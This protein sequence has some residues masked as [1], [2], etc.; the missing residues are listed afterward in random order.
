MTVVTLLAFLSAACLPPVPTPGRAGQVKRVLI[1]GDSVTFGL[2]GTS[3]QVQTPLRVMLADRGVDL[4]VQGFPAEN[5][6]FVWPGHFGWS[7]RMQHEV[8]TWD[9][10]M[11]IV[12]SMLFPDSDDAARRTAY[13][14]AIA[15]IFDIARS[16]GAHVYTV[17]HHVP[18]GTEWSRGREVAESLQAE[19][20][21]SRQIQRIPLDWWMA[22]CPDGVIGDGVHLTEK[23]QRCNALAIIT[24]VDQLRSAVG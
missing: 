2:F 15:E 6:L 17:S 9:P 14:N 3:P 5:P 23:G 12:Q 20:A 21:A 18:P 8:S 11:I 7:L 4:H 22:R 1:L 19:A 24:A 13:S 10:D 16:R